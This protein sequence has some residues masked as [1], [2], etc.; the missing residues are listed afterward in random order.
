ML[1]ADWLQCLVH[2]INCNFCPYFF[3]FFT[4]VIHIQIDLPP[5]HHRHHQI[6][7]LHYQFY[8][9]VYCL[10]LFSVFIKPCLLQISCD[11]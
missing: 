4:F 9:L 7:C 1:D 10:H 3:S 2:V 11:L 5:P 8:I 6:K